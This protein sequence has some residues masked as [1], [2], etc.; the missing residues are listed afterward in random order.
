M[1]L[2]EEWRL[3][4]MAWGNGQRELLISSFLFF[5]AI[6]V[7]VAVLV[8]NLTNEGPYRPIEDI[9]PQTVVRVTQDF[10]EVHAVKC[11][12]SD[13][14][15][16]VEGRA[17][18]RNVETQELILVREGGGIRKPGCE[19]IRFVNR[20]P[21]GIT[22]GRWRIE[23]VEIARAG[24]EEQREPWYTEPFDLPVDG[25]QHE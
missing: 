16:A 15:V 12:K 8:N 19:T 18:F 24:T 7:L 22:A 25:G 10:V 5:A 13:R 21:A 20:I 2:R 9:N 14:D 1:N 11:N 23:G 17:Y 4:R 3:L 6:L